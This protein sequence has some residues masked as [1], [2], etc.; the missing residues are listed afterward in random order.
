MKSERQRRMRCQL[1][2]LTTFAE[3]PIE[4]TDLNNNSIELSVGAVVLWEGGV[5]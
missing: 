2:A 1:I 4:T 5:T 3:N